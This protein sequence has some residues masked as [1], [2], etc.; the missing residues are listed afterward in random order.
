MT[1]STHAWVEISFNLTYLAAT[2]GLVAAMLRRQ[3]HLS[4]ER[5]HLT[6]PFVGAFALLA[7]AIFFWGL[8]RYES[9]NLVTVRG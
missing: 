3:P 7:R 9:G 6:R 2:W 4:P 1:E 8:Q 5:Q